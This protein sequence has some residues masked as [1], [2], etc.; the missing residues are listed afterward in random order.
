[1]LRLLKI[2]NLVAYVLDRIVEAFHKFDRNGLGK[3][4]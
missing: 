4:K 2:I 3:P 1:M